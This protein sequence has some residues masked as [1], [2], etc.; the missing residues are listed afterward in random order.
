MTQES[1]NVAHDFAS[2]LRLTI[3]DAADYVSQSAGSTAQTLR[4]VD[5]EVAQGER[6]EAGLKKKPE[7]EKF[8]NKD[9]REQFEI[10]MDTVKDAGSQTIGAA[11]VA[12]ATSKDLANRTNDRLQNAFNEV[13]YDVIGS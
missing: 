5:E 10:T 2:F 13:S 4:Q 11:Q 8:K 6:N 1:Q 7:E 3:A 12:A 9:A